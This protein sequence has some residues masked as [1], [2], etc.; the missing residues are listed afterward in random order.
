MGRFV[1]IEAAPGVVTVVAAIARD[2]L[3]RVNQDEVDRGVEEARILFGF[4]KPS[5]P[6]P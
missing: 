4:K 3:V 1:S 5:S 2:A 6:P